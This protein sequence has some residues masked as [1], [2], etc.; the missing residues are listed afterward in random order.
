MEPIKVLI[1]DDEADY[2]NSLA[3]VL[4]RRGFQVQK[5]ENGQAALDALAADRFDVIVL[6][7]RMPVMDGLT[8]LQEIRKTDILTPVILLSGHAVVAYVHQ[9]L[10]GGAVD[11]LLK[12]CPVETLVSALETACE[13]RAISAEWKEQSDRKTRG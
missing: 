11:Y 4:S 12:P 2:V 3:K 10:K 6:D 13:H 9:A 7:L 1:A 5:A 8:A